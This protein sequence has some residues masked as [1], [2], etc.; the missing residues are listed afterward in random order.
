MKRV[1]VG[2]L[3]MLASS[4][5]LIASTAL[6]TVVNWDIDPSAS[7]FKLA[8]P[9]QN[10]TIG[11]L[12]ATMRLRNE[13]NT[14]WTTN[15]APV[16][17]LLA[18]NVGA[19]ISSVQFLGGSSSLVGVQTGSYRPNPA[20]YDTNVTDATNSDGTFT[21]SS[22]AAGVYAARV[23]ASISIITTNLGYIAFD[24]MSFDVSSLVT[25]VTGTSFL[26]NALDVGI[27]DSTIEFD[28]TAP[29]TS[30][31]GDSLVQSG[32]ISATN[33]NAAAG[34]IVNIG[35]NDYKI[36]IPI[37][38]PVMVSLSGV[39]LNATA[40]GTL[41]GYATIPVPEPTTIALAGLGIAGL[42]AYGRRRR[43]S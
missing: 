19:G 42:A 15:S 17:G 1:L 9:D 7:S 36:T 11:T 18:T 8:V 3:A 5:G 40:T 26:A 22:S 28:S 12:T 34:S 43:Q 32:P 41:V 39:N 16:D 29:G 21:N 25:A 24:N 20:A 30:G 37:N 14:T 13:N 33:I 27:L 23:N 31:I 4:T 35:G 6:A 10:V 2:A 38:M